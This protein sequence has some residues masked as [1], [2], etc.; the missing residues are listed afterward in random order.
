MTVD[1]AIHQILAA[2]I[3]VKMMEIMD[4]IAGD[5]PVY[6]LTR[7]LLVSSLMYSA[8]RSIKVGRELEVKA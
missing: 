8:Y 1:E 7:P 3:T 2:V 5:N 4:K 6:H